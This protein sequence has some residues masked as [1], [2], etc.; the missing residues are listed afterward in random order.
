MAADQENP[1]EIERR[2]SSGT[3]SL[4]SL[5]WRT[6]TDE[7]GPY[8]LTT[9]YCPREPLVD[10]V[11][12]H[13]LRGG[14]YKTWQKYRE[15]SYLWP[16]A[17]LP[18]E[19]GLE[20]VR[21]HTFGYNSDWSERKD[22]ILNIYDFGRS[23]LAEMRS[24]PDLRKDKQAY[25][26]SRQESATSDLAKRI[27]SIFFLATPHR[28]S[29]SANLLNNII[30][31][32]GT[33]TTRPYV[34]DLSKN[35]LSL[36]I[37]NDEFRHFSED[38]RL[39]SFYET[40]K[41]NIG[42]T[43]TLIVERD[44]SVLGYKDEMIYPMNANHREV[45][46][47]D[48]PT[49]PNYRTVR[50]ALVLAVEDILQDNSS[51][52]EDAKRIQM[53][54][55]GDFLGIHGPPLDDLQDLQELV[56]PGSCRWFLESPL[57]Q[58]WL[59]EDSEYARIY[60]LT[61]KPAAG[62]SVLAAHVV[63][64]L[65]GL[66]LDCSYYFFKHGDKTKQLA[67]GLLRSL[68]YQCASSSDDF[69]RLL[70][71][72]QE[73]SIQFDLDD[74]R[75]IWRKVFMNCLLRAPVS[76]LQFWVID[77]LD[78]CVNTARFIPFLAKIES[79]F[80]I[81]I[82]V[83]CRPTT[84]LDRHF[85]SWGF[86]LV[87]SEISI[88]DSLKD[89][90]LY[91]Q[92]EAD[93]LPI[94]DLEKRQSLIEKIISKSAGCFLWIR[95]VLQEL[96]RAWSEQQIEDILDEVPPEMEPLYDRAV[97]IISRNA[98]SKH[99][100]HAILTWVL[101]AVRPL[102]TAEL[103]D[104]LER[105][106]NMKMFRFDKSV[107]TL[108]GH[109]IS[110]QKSGS[111]TMVHTTAREYLLHRVHS[112][113]FI[114]DKALSHQKMAMTCLEYLAGEEM[115][116]PRLGG[117]AYNSRRLDRSLFADY[118]CTAF[119]EHIAN[120]PS[121][122][123]EL[124]ILLHKFLRTN[125][126]TWIEYIAQNHDLYYLMRT[127]KNLRQYLKRRAKHV[128]PLGVEFQRVDGWSTDLM[129]VP[130]KFGRRLTS[131]PSS[132]Y[133]L[134]P[135][136]C[137][138]D[139]MI[140]QQGDL[141][142]NRIRV[143]GLSNSTWEDCVAWIEYKSTWATA[144]ACGDNFLALGMKSG[145]VN[146]Y[147]QFTCQE[148]HVFQHGEP[149]KILKFDGTSRRLISAG[150]RHLRLWTI[151]GELTWTSKLKQPCVTVSFAEDDSV[152]LV[153]T[154]SNEGLS[155]AVADGSTP[156]AATISADA[157]T[158]ALVYRGRPVHLWSV[159][160]DYLFAFCGRDAGKQ[161]SN[162]SPATALFNPNSKVSL[163][164]IGY[165][166]CFLGIYDTETQEERNIVSG[167][168]M[169]L[170]ATPDGR[171]LGTSDAAGNLCLWDFE[172]LTLLYRVRSCDEGLKSLSFSGDGL[173]IFDIRDTITEFWEPLA[174]VRKNLD[175]DSS[176]SDSVH[177]APATE[178]F[179]AERAMEITALM[180]LP[181]CDTLLVAKEDGSVVC[182]DSI[183]G[184]EGHK[185][186]SH[187]KDIFVTTMTWC[188]QGNMLA[189]ADVGGRVLIWQLADAQGWQASKLLL[190]CHPRQSV[191]Q[192]L[193]SPKGDRLIVSTVTRDTL[194]SISK[195]SESTRQLATL[196]HPS[197]ATWR[198][199]VSHRNDD[200]VILMLDYDISFYTW[201]DLKKTAD[202]GVSL[203]FPGNSLLEAESTEL[204]TFHVSS[205]KSALLANFT[206]VRRDRSSAA[207]LIWASTSMDDGLGRSNNCPV[208]IKPFLFQ[209]VKYFIGIAGSSLLVFLDNDLFLCSCD[210]SCLVPAAGTK[211]HDAKPRYTR[212]YF[213][214][215]D[216]VTRTRG[217][218][219]AVTAKGDVAF[220]KDG[221]IAVVSCPLES[222]I[223]QRM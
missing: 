201:A 76:G 189:T 159:E 124:M 64:H 179:E 78:E 160:D 150:A 108:C 203:D 145:A 75:A 16:Q 129:R 166:D 20:N 191:R 169:A 13:G 102:K 26:L 125:V 193:L 202:L 218:M 185:L 50:N 77:A 222:F 152:I 165:Q 183:S 149:V 171:T 95:V 8:G 87:R 162:I 138:K 90:R 174:L 96:E 223:T 67:S 48:S 110:I 19:A 164:A 123:N 37:I 46:K 62:K 25:I 10:F 194:W 105:G 94:S 195:D 28:G 192:L 113:G 109:L 85:T 36:Q 83:T 89:I 186:F 197:R 137:P 88:E 207:F 91:L 14:S 69:R 175:E 35:S 38:V 215:N 187:T 45:C 122:F 34:K 117:K 170:A 12:V 104:A 68:A 153:A 216:F 154:R 40:M 100:A 140:R 5:S 21:I 73:D 126:S 176:V 31:A 128:S 30:R 155:L 116:P 204:Q 161:N 65:Q 135:P 39:W 142:P 205:D 115:R 209:S 41:T 29:D 217:S 22:S 143:S 43:S 139:S 190:D 163:L 199:T 23:L 213:I 17:W 47:F 70:N 103:Q 177:V 74:E 92:N 24:C 80:R 157:K 52:R 156:L 132:I 151:N 18:C 11:F 86:R 2:R 120:A 66:G 42:L 63:S 141:G 32:T 93:C 178:R 181:S 144:M 1:Q 60:W 168:G 173:R 182:Y 106:M 51:S 27:R 121:A 131:I 184:V 196:E 134:I 114:V 136:F 147:N 172:T 7:I 15:P 111:I 3:S 107:E 101:C 84:E 6:S 71:L 180:S 82:L 188:D 118:A 210:I 127:A 33:M 59:Q 54:H 212:H 211:N 198:W 53:Q 55:L 208:K 99:I 220:V 61:S 119:S 9:L 130:A 167:G 148:K 206:Q 49:D 219:A 44:S 200:E 58:K 72:L 112:S 81:R 133:F 146:L 98:Q 56:A 79:A 214:P 97:E 158:L 4:L 57:F 221:E